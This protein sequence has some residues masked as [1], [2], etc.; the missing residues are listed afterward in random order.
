MGR[1]WVEA[2][3]RINLRQKRLF[4][5]FSF[6]TATLD[7]TEKPGFGR[8]FEEVGPKPTGFWTNLRG[9]LS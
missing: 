9:V 8:F 6:G 7:L 2:H 1:V 5:N 4:Q 3:R